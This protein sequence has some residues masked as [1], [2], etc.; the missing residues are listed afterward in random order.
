MIIAIIGSH[1]YI[2]TIFNGYNQRHDTVVMIIVS[3]THKFYIKDE[4]KSC[5]FVGNSQLK[6]VDYI[7][8]F[9]LKENSATLIASI[10]SSTLSKTTN[11]YSNASSTSVKN[12][13]H[14]VSGKIA[15][16]NEPQENQ[17]FSDVMS[18]DQ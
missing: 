7:A 10:V 15:A 12:T 3:Y 6:P 5:N 8:L 1:N 9:K 16:V 14:E 18:I 4:N 13:Y 11:K 2:G 17:P